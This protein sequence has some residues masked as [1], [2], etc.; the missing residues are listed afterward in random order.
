[1]SEYYFLPPSVFISSDSNQTALTKKHK[2]KVNYTV[3]LQI[4]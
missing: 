3:A 4:Y 2:N 1:M